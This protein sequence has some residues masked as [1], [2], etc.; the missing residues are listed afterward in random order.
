M[1]ADGM[2]ALAQVSEKAP[3]E[4]AAAGQP[5]EGRR[6]SGAFTVS[7]PVRPPGPRAAHF[8]VIARYVSRAQLEDPNIR[9]QVLEWIDFHGEASRI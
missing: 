8:P 7:G 5:L 9:Q 4:E 3:S 1:N 6:S 2:R